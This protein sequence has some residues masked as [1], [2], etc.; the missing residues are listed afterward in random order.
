MYVIMCVNYNMY[1]YILCLIFLSV[2]FVKFNI[3][4]SVELP[5]TLNICNNI[6]IIKRK[7]D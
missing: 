5:Y 6:F 7:T 1:V 4:K 3:I 2:D